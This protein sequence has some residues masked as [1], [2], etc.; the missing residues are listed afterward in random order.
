M[1]GGHR[2]EVFIAL[3]IVQAF[4]VGNAPINDLPARKA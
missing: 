1:R 3:D 4:L 2:V